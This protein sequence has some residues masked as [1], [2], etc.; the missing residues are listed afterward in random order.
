MKA[1]QGSF[2]FVPLMRDLMYVGSQSAPL[3]ALRYQQL[4]A[5]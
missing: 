4:L 3:G 1:S 5:D 2:I